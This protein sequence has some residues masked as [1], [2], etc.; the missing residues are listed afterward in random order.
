MPEIV[1]QDPVRP[2]GAAQ[3]APVAQ[4][5]TFFGSSLRWPLRSTIPTFLPTFRFV[6]AKIGD[7]DSREFEVVGPISQGV[8]AWPAGE[9]MVTPNGNWR[10]SATSAPTLAMAAVCWRA[11]LTLSDTGPQFC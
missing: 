7:R 6:A 10:S 3:D 8:V 1:V 2:G 11:E 9:F 4:R 5:A